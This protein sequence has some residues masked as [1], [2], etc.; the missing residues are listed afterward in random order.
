MVNVRRVTLS[1]FGVAVAAVGV[2][3]VA[4]PSSAAVPLAATPSVTSGTVSPS[5]RTPQCEPRGTVQIP[6]SPANQEVVRAYPRGTVFSVGLWENLSTG[7]AWERSSS[8][9]SDMIVS[10]VDTKSVRDPA[11][12]NL[13]GS[14]AIR[15]FR[16]ETVRPGAATITLNYRRSWE[17]VPPIRQVVLRIWV[18]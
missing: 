5:P 11:M 18:R 8:P 6:D 9:E 15:C 3:A 1:I 17:T 12:P 2:V 7:Y 16:F 13:P 4:A 14:G 10:F